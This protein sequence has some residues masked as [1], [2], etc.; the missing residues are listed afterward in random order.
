[1]FS[2]VYICKF[3]HWKLELNLYK[4][5]VIYCFKVWTYFLKENLTIEERVRRKFFTHLEHQ[6]VKGE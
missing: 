5:V 2:T 3:V 1:M 4:E 6:H